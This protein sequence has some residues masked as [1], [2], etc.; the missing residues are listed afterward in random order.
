MFVDLFDF[1]DGNP[2]RLFEPLSP[3]IFGGSCAAL[4]DGIELCFTRSFCL[5]QRSSEAGTF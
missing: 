2:R 4:F 3:S 5:L 1:V